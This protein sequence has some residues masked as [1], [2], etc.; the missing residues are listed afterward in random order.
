M[1]GRLA[2]DPFH[3][4]YPMKTLLLS[5]VAATIMISSHFAFAQSSEGKRAL[6]NFADYRKQVDLTHRPFDDG[7]SDYE[8]EGALKEAQRTFDLAKA[9]LAKV[10]EGD[11]KDPRYVEGASWVGSGAPAFARWQNERVQNAG[12]A[13]LRGPAEQAYKNDADTNQTVLDFVKSVRADGGGSMTA[14]EMQ[15]RWKAS[16][17]LSGFAARCA[18][19]YAYVDRVSR[20]G[21]EK[22]E[23]CK[24][25]AEWKALLTSSFESGASANVKAIAEEVRHTVARLKEGSSVDGP[26]IKKL[27][28]S[29]AHIRDIRPDFEV[30]FQTMGRPIPADLF[31]PIEV[32]SRDSSSA[33]ATALTKTRYKAAKFSDAG[34]LAAVK[35]AFATKSISV[36]QVSQDSNEW[37]IQKDDLGTPLK[38]IRVSVSL[39][40]APQESFCR[41]Y[42]PFAFQPY[43]GGG[44]YSSTTVE[45]PTEPEFQVVPC[46]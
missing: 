32:A 11:R 39:T 28:D 3:R 30:L 45:L 25:A 2:Q 40:R 22:V 9:W 21:A 37:Q 14:K 46:K 16:E 8:A 6:N 13:K 23:N 15:N 42:N 4:R 12:I 10:P 18:K 43:A 20:Y 31:A 33:I 19:E 29:S 44:K 5:A 24:N 7:A 36:L 34:I 35:S 38:R 1:Q 17:A 41:L 26:S 27:V